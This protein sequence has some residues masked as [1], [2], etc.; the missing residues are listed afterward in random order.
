[1]GKRQV[2]FFIENEVFKKFS[3]KC[4]DLEKSKTHVIVELIKNFVK[5]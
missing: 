4:I 5:E 3:K 1:M 2:S